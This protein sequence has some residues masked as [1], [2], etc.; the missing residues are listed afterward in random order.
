MPHRPTLPTLQALRA[1][2]SVWGRVWAW[3]WVC[4]VLLKAAVPL[5]AASAAQW[6]G[7]A[8]ADV[9][10]AY[11]V[12]TVASGGA[13]PSPE[14]PHQAHADKHCALSPLLGS[15]GLL[16]SSATADATSAQPPGPV[17]QRRALP[18]PPDASQRWLAH[19]LHAPPQRA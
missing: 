7:A 19:R 1:Q 14:S 5:L 11:G 12:R 6:Q 4:A 2:R 8:M 16:P 15:S 18:T 13:A 9:C 17:P 10:S 3:A